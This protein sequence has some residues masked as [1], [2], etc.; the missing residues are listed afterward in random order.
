MARL[1]SNVYALGKQS[2]LLSL[3]VSLL[4]LSEFDLIK[5]IIK[6]NCQLLNTIA[7]SWHDKKGA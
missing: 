1:A 3:G 2:N 7:Q 5:L 4:T 6:L